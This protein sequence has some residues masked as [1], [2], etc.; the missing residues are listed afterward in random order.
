M[1]VLYSRNASQVQKKLFLGVVSIGEGKSF[2]LEGVCGF[3]YSYAV[4][5]SPIS[6]IPSILNLILPHL[7]KTIE[8]PCPLDSIRTLF[9]LFSGG[10]LR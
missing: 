4:T 8:R 7:Q 9:Y 3:F 1:Y 10:P 2:C 5:L 6:H